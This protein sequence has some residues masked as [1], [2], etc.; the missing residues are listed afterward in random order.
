MRVTSVGDT[1]L[2]ALSSEEVSLLVDLCHAGVFSDYLA[3]S[4]ERREHLD[5][6]HWQAQQSL[7]P[8]VQRRHESDVR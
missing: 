4:R 8:S 5:T 7:L 6:F 1:H 3:P 2:L